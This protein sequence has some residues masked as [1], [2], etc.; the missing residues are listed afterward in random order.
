MKIQITESDIK[1]MVMEGV[2]MLLREYNKATGSIFF[3]DYENMIDNFIEN[4]LIPP[5]QK[6][7]MT[8]L[9]GNVC[10]NTAIDGT[11]G[12]YYSP[13]RLYGP[14]EDCHPEE[15]DFW[16]DDMDTTEFENAINELQI[17][18]NLKTAIIDYANNWLENVDLE[19]WSID[20][21]DDSYPEP[22]DD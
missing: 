18:D 13:A 22:D 7:S 12:W 4:G 8:Q 19:A 21:P 5:E 3:S 11:F 16:M 17:P 20:E 2:R 1:H 14:P 10:D 6:A 15:S 9:I